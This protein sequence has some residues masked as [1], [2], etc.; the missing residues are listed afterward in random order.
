MKNEIKKTSN[1]IY[2]VSMIENCDYKSLKEI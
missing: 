1:Q 2:Y